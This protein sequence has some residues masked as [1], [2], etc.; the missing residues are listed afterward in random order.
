MKKTTCNCVLPWYTGTLTPTP[1]PRELGN[2]CTSR[3]FFLAS[4][5]YHTT[6]PNQAVFKR[7]WAALKWWQSCSFLW[8]RWRSRKSFPTKIVPLVHAVTDRISQEKDSVRGLILQSTGSAQVERACQGCSASHRADCKWQ[9]ENKMTPRS[10]RCRERKSLHAPDVGSAQ[11]LY[12]T[13]H[14]ATTFL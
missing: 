6:H 5:S 13:L 9:H 8:L 14:V 4:Q 10:E 3:R 7:K 11:C 2:S 12:F 1:L